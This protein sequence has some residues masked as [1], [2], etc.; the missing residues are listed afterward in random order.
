[1]FRK[2]EK[3]IS[4]CV[5]R[6]GMLLMVLMTLVVCFTV[7]TRYC[8][9]FT[10]AWGEE[11]ALLFMVWFGFLAM[12]LGVRDDLHL[13]I[14]IL[15]KVTPKFLK[16][17]MDI[18]KYLCCGG[19]GVFMTYYGWDMVK[20]G[21]RNKFPGMRIP[22]AVLYL[23]VP[24][25]GIAIIVYAIMRIIGLFDPDILPD[26]SDDPEDMETAPAAEIDIPG[27]TTEEKE[28]E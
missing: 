9:K 16:I 22:S 2:F 24:V 12:A 10:P 6:L 17:P 19:F 4:W 27:V 20:I 18:I 26:T 11:S 15:D 3:S 8:F 13:S 25:A 1:M 23:A 28:D 21:M 5:E 7:V 14:T